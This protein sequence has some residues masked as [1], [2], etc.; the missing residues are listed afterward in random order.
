MARRFEAL[1]VG[2]L[3]CGALVVGLHTSILRASDA[4]QT[5]A[6]ASSAPAPARTPA[7]GSAAEY[8]VTVPGSK[9]YHRPGCDLVR[10]AK[11]PAVLLKSQAEGRGLKPHADCDP[12]N[13]QP[14]GTPKP[15]PVFVY[16][17]KD[18]NKYHKAEC[19][20]VRK[21]A[22]RVRLDKDAV[23]GRWPCTVCRAPVRAIPKPA[24]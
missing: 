24:R 5:P 21:D 23:R 7:A 6:A 19:A 18:D 15:K 9:E 17:Q 4:S 12:V 22:T 16:I 3:L 2:A 13:L 8:V 20:L 14:D 1:A 11:A 10:A